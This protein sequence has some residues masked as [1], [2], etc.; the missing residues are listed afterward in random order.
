MS[1]RSK[2]KLERFIS[3]FCSLFSNKGMHHSPVGGLYYFLAEK[4][5]GNRT[6]VI[7]LTSEVDKHLRNIGGPESDRE[8]CL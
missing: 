7:F 8:D 3:K 4:A 6:K 1:F 2:N 5:D